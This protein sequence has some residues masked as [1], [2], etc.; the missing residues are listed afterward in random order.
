MAV[1]LEIRA[2]PLTGKQFAVPE[3]EPLTVGRTERANVAVPGDTQMS[4]V[5]FAL[6]WDGKVC[7][8]VDKRST[9][10]TLLN[11]N[12]VSEST[13]RDGDVIGAGNTKFIVRFMRSPQNAATPEAAGVAPVSQAVAGSPE[14]K[15]SPEAPRADLPAVPSIPQVTVP[16]IPSA[17]AAPA[18]PAIPTGPAILAVSGIAAAAMPGA[19]GGAHGLLVGLPALPIALGMKVP[20]IPAVPVMPAIPGKPSVSA[21]AIPNMPGVPQVPGVALPGMPGVPSM[22]NVA[23]P[24]VALPQTP[25]IPSLPGVA[26]PQIPRPVV[27]ALTAAQ[28][29]AM[30]EEAA[31]RA[32]KALWQA[33]LVVGG[34][35][36]MVIPKGWVVPEE[37]IGIHCA[38]PG[39]FPA[40]I[41]AGEE[42]LGEGAALVA[43]RDAHVS[44]MRASMEEQ[45]ITEHQPPQ[46]PGAEKVLAMDVVYKNSNGAG[47]LLRRLY[48]QNGRMAGVLT[49]M[50]LMDEFARIVPDLQ[51]IQSG[52][53]YEPKQPA[54]AASIPGSTAAPL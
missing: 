38:H 33:S 46:I 29:A 35:K 4:G 53:R 3:G 28:L 18:I 5:H 19:P 21:P 51:V 36:F 22:P 17:P 49:L 10:G 16:N 26:V 37:R 20:Q 1:V 32:L 24:S 43:L 12:P 45:R 27:P 30:V 41:L 39:L 52:L 42:P 34:W 9:N 11:G 31:R 40:H 47:V 44:M 50:T 25:G 2:G 48:A 54:L 14:K 15:T 6:E 23:I 13:L 7:R 8:V